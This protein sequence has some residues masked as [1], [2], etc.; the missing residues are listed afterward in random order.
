MVLEPI[1]DFLADAVI[2][3]DIGGP[4]LGEM[5]AHGLDRAASQLSKPTR[6]CGPAVIQ[7]NNELVNYRIAEQSAEP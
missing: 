7:E 6:S 2:P 5:T 1:A 4:E 3:D